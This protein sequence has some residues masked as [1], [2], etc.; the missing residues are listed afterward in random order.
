MVLKRSKYEGLDGS[1][2]VQPRNEPV[3]PDTTIPQEIEMAS[4]SVVPDDTF[5]VTQAVNALGFGWFQVKL[6]LWTGLCW[7]ADSMEMTILSILSPALHCS[8][9]ITRYQQA[10]TTT[11]VFLGMMLSSTFWGNL[12]DRYGRKHALSLCAVLLFYYGLLSSIAPSFMWMLLLRGLVGFAIGCT[13][14]SVTLYAEFLPTKQRAKCVV[15][16]DCFWALG[17]CFE[18][19]LAL[20][21]MPTLG[22]Q[23]LLALSTGP[24]LAFAMIC[25]WLPESARYHVVSGQ[26]DKALETLEKIAKDNGKPMLLGRL[27]VDEA[28]LN[29]PHRGRLRD[30]LIPSLRLTSLLLWFIWASCA[31]CYYG[32]VLMTT[33]LFETTTIVCNDGSQPVQGLDTCAAD[34]RQLQT[35]DYV[36]LLWTTL[37][38]F[39]GIF[40]TIFIIERFGRKKTMAVQFIA[41]AVCCGFL[42]VC[43]GKRSVLTVMLFFARGIIA[44]VF[45]AAYV[46]TPEVYPTS[47][48]SIGVGS[49]SAMARLGAMVTPY[50][51]QVLLK[52]SIS[53]ATSTYASA[54][55]LAA[56]AC[57]IL[58]I[59]TTG[60]ELPD[61]TVEHNQ[62]STNK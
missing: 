50:V 12:S 4:V 5:T 55:V 21:V 41:Y 37:A 45:Q 28:S 61:N 7:M 1:S 13:P 15:L 57:L 58:P 3:D 14:Q 40:F 56:I 22:W 36:D 52:T 29:S 42:A 43:P 49:C 25:P 38:E 35:A 39:P 47:L 24:L 26:T 8:W 30:L 10:L 48:R 20:V 18:V 59:E 44:G 62:A 54:A 19:A 33:E 9:H 31:F 53:F 16:L 23:W 27:V 6:S 60:K 11:I 51:A 32:L 2:S 46:Y 34:C 17:A